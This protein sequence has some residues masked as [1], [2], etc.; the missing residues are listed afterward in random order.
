[1]AFAIIVL[2]WN[3]IAKECPVHSRGASAFEETWALC[4]AVFRI[5]VFKYDRRARGW[6]DREPN[7]WLGCDAAACARR[8]SSRNRTRMKTRTLTRIATCIVYEINHFWWRSC[9]KR[10]LPTL[11]VWTISGRRTSFLWTPSNSA[12]VL[13]V[14]TVVPPPRTFCWLALVLPHHHVV[15]N[16]ER[17][18]LLFFPV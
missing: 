5:K 18:T 10:G 6:L 2:S 17:L 7:S 13:L 3:Y 14:H 4:N 16:F 15:E 11:L 8:V 1:M 9:N 12:L